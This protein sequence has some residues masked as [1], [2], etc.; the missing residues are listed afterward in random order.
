MKYIPSWQKDT[1]ATS[2]TSFYCSIYCLE[3]VLDCWVYCKCDPKT[4]CN[5]LL[6]EH[7]VFCTEFVQKFVKMTPKPYKLTPLRGLYC[8][9][10]TN[11]VYSW[12]TLNKYLPSGSLE[13]ILGLFLETLNKF[14]S[15]AAQHFCLLAF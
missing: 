8:E 11:L 13:R 3:N 6:N 15:I 12:T 10:W 14:L 7:A 2:L 1:R 4:Y 9:L 5:V